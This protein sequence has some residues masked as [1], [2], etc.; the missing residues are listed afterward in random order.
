M[1]IP[2]FDLE[3]I[4]DSSGKLTPQAKLLFDQIITLL[5]NILSDQG[6]AIPKQPTSTINQ[7]DKVQTIGT[8]VYDSS[9]NQYKG[10]INGTYKVFTLT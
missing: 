3:N 10:N 6:I 9:T 5:Q 1:S 2:N 7:F 4:S 8:I